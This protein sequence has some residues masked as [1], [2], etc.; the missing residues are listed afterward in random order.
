MSAERIQEYTNI[1][2]EVGVYTDVYTYTRV[3]V[4]GVIALCHAGGLNELRTLWV[5]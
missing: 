3:F 2:Q 5:Y 1:E 4:F